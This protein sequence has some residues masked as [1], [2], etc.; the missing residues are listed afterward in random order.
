MN[1]VGAPTQPSLGGQFPGGQFG[2]PDSGN[3]GGLF[4]ILKKLGIVGGG[5]GG[6]MGLGMGGGGGMANLAGAQ[7]P[8]AQAPAQEGDGQDGFN[9]MSLM[10]GPGLQNPQMLG[11]LLPQ[12]LMGKKGMF[13][14]NFLGGL[15]GM[16]GK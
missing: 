13:G 10:I 8:Q 7:E 15:G 2:G 4:A 11:G 14:G 3:L 1:F 12:M 6:G 16:F 9:P 5:A